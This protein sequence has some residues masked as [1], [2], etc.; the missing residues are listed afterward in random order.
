MKP[1]IKI[2][3]ADKYEAQKLCTMVLVKGDTYIV[4]I[5]DIINDEVIVS[6]KD[7]SAH[8]ILLHNNIEAERLAAYMQEVFEGIRHVYN[9]EAVHDVVSI[10]SKYYDT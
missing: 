10:R 9:A 5:L 8:S 7:T 2:R 4:S 1:N 6:L 3:C